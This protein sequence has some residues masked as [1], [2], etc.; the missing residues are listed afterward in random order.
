[1][2]FV[3]DVNF[4]SPHAKE[5]LSNLA[6]MIEKMVKLMKVPAEDMYR[7]VSLYQGSENSSVNRQ[8]LNE[9]EPVFVA[10]IAF[11]LDH[12]NKKAIPF[13]VAENQEQL[14]A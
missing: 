6:K 3:D 8:V 4:L 14:I 11:F 7:N 12:A 1:M 10:G 2:L 5:K 13:V 9:W